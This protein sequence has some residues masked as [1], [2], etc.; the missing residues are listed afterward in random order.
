MILDNAKTIYYDLVNPKES[1]VIAFYKV[2]EGYVAHIKKI[3][4][5]WYPKTVIDVFFD[6]FHYRFEEIVDEEFDMEV[7]DFI[8]VIITNE[9]DEARYYSAKI[10]GYLKK[11]LEK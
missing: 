8:K 11:W 3:K 7:R 2:P 1:K 4:I 9:S 10:R 6:N 5:D